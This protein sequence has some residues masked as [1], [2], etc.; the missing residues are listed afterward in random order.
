[1]CRRGEA[2]ESA[3]VFDEEFPEF[4]KTDSSSSHLQ[5]G[6]CHVADHVMQESIS[7][8][9]QNQT[10]PHLFHFTAKNAPDRAGYSGV[11]LR[12]TGKV[13]IPLK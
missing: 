5:Q 10:P 12:K 3:V 1:M 7:F 13:M 11:R 6:S 4:L 9:G 8:N 2:G